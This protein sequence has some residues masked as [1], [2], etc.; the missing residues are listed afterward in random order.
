MNK[1]SKKIKN[2]KIKTNN[3]ISKSNSSKKLKKTK[4]SKQVN[5]F[6]C[7][8]NTCRSAALQALA[9]A[10]YPELIFESCGTGVRTGKEGEGMSIPMV[11]RIKAKSLKKKSKLLE[12]KVYKKAL[13]H[14]MSHKSRSCTCKNIMKVSNSGGIMFVVA[15]SNIAN[16][17]KIIDDCSK[18]DKNFKKPKITKIHKKDI[19]D[20]YEKSCELLV[21]Q[22]KVC[23][24]KSLRR[25]KKEY[26][27][28]LTQI[29]KALK[30]NKLIKEM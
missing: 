12:P 17:K 7:T 25:E 22:G 28:S 3:K 5:Q 1:K 23:N 24:K 11:F 16:L 4:K 10:M 6:V 21:R 27:V 30:N 14:A 20:G 26:K 2:P 13:E 8:G 29:V 19:I 15:D 9:R 18:K